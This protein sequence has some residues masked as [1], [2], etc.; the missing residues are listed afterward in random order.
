[1]SLVFFIRD[2]LGAMERLAAISPDLAQRT[3]SH[4][5]RRL[6]PFLFVLYVIAYI[7]RINIGFAGLQMTGELGFSNEVF[8]F[9][10]GIFFVGYILLGIPGAMLVQRWS[11]R[12][13]I[14]ATLL[15]WG[16]VA[17]ATGLIHSRAEFYF[18]RFLLGVAEAGFFP[19]V[20][21]YL[22]LWYIA[23]DRAKAVAMFMAAIPVSQVIAAPL[24][25][26]LMRVTWL[27]MAGWRW[28][29]ILEGIPALVCGLVSWYYLTDRPRLASWL[30]AE[31]REWLVGELEREQAG[32][33]A[34]ERMPFLKVLQ[35]RDVLLLCLTYFGGTMGNYGLNLWLPK[36]I[37][38][39]GSLSAE[40]T[41]L[42]SAIPAMAA[43]PAMLINGWHSDRSGERRWHTAIPR[44]VGGVAL[45][46]AA[47]NVQ[48]I[49]VPAV[50][51]LFSIA[52]AG[53]VAAYPP[54]WAIPGNVLSI[55]AA[56][57]SIGLISSLGNTGGFAG[58][59]IIGWITDRTGTYAGGLWAVA[60][61]LF[62][63]GVFTLFVR[64]KR[65]R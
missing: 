18:M 56:A 22:N 54:L 3:R 15:V 42:I 26:A 60:A 35:Q 57:A 28:L 2:T 39:V 14:A 44:C 36:I 49:G 11:A 41:S 7:D 59:Y 53:V 4:V 20:I 19:G 31:E 48:T 5:T 63:S 30:M 33:T 58:P 52:L 24:S 23:R 16:C 8:G 34:A 32:K 12:R 6:L 61:A 37:Q 40:K 21:T 64:E 47:L 29:L 25:A 46:L 17:S 55:S 65:R 51:V 50:V 62:L 9:G 38:K 13:A 45:G 43:V 1:L 10:S 27:G